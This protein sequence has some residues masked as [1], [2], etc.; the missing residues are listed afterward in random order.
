MALITTI[1]AADA[2]SYGTLAG[3]IAYATSMGWTLA[4]DE[5]SQNADMR[6]AAAYLD[7]E[8]D[9]V[10]QRVNE[11]QAL[12]WPRYCSMT[13][14]DGFAIPYDEIPTPIIKAQYEVAYLF[15]QGN[16]LLAFTSGAAIKR[17][18]K[19]LDVLEKTT[20]Y[21]TASDTQPRVLAIEGLLRGYITNA[22]QGQTS[23]MIRRDRG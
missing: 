5:D 4:G 6:R 18:T 11:T 13:D 2:D 20:E 15:N 23:G 10:G 22:S 16:D 19:K 14:V 17:E 3:L 1:G 21:E 9:Y 7:R 12:G 8:S